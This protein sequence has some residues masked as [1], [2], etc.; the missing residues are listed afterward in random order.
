MKV[1]GM[2]KGDRDDDSEKTAVLERVD[3]GLFPLAQDARS[4]YLI[5]ISGRHVGNMHKLANGDSVLGRAPNCAVIIDDEGVSRQHARIERGAEGCV[6]YDNNS[7]N[8]VFVNGEQVRRHVL[9]DG[10]R[11][12]IGSKTI[13]KFSFTDEVEE[14]FQKQLYDSATRDGLTGTF[15]KKYFADQLKTEFAFF[16]RHRSNL[17]LVLFDIDFFKKLN[18]GFGHLAGDHVLRDLARVVE[19]TLRVEDIFARYGGEEF[20]VILRDTDGERAFLI[21]ERMRRAVEAHEF[22]FDGQR[23]PV[24]ISV[25]VTTCVE[26]EHRSPRELIQATDQLLYDAKRK[27]RN[28]TESRALL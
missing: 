23:L 25:G 20:G 1:Q 24:T 9:Q 8:G 12:Q 6:L 2:G 19:K 11:V 26:D 22:M 27:G 5:T 21:A 10:D 4:A 18:D 3:L 13:L 17:S 7:T 16:Q 28:R 14:K 15:N